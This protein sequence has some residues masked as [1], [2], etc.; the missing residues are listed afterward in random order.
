VY[1][2]N[3]AK[4]EGPRIA[5]CGATNTS[6]FLA[7]EWEDFTNIT[8]EKKAICSRKRGGER[9]FLRFVFPKERPAV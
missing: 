1:Y 4:K 5:L 2:L 8:I 9:V 3:P 6:F 7:Q